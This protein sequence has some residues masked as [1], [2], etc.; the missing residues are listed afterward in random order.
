MHTSMYMFMSMFMPL[1]RPCSCSLSCCMEMNMDMDI[2]IKIV[3]NTGTETK[4]GIDIQKFRYRISSKSLILISTLGRNLPSSVR[5]RRFRYQAPSKTVHHGYRTECPPMLNAMQNHK[6]LSNATL[7][8][9]LPD[10]PRC[11]RPNVTCN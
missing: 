4:M 11:S 9:K 1:L 2:D 10:F 6:M 5:Y 8:P 7:W 3:T